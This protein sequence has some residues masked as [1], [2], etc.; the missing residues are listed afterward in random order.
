MEAPRPAILVPTPSPPPSR[1]EVA[2]DPRS[3]PGRA[4]PAPSE[5]SAAY[6][7]RQGCLPSASAFKCGPV[8]RL[9]P[10]GSSSGPCCRMTLWKRQSSKTRSRKWCQ[11][12]PSL[13]QPALP[14]PLPLGRSLG[15][16][17]G[18]QSSQDLSLPTRTL[19]ASSLKFCTGEPSCRCLPQLLPPLTI[20]L[21]PG[22]ASGGA[23]GRS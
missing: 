17:R 6:S 22:V 23:A 1:P 10:M 15:K 9:I 11:H 7:V 20:P 16:S 3:N 8:I 18:C 21:S 13:P 2:S 12:Q 4:D 14:L 19:P 5:P